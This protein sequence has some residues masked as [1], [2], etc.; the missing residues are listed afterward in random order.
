[1]IGG[2][3]V[4]SEN[5]ITYWDES[6]EPVRTAF[7]RRMGILDERG[8]LIVS[9]A[10]HVQKNLFFFLVQSE[11]GDIYKV[12]LQYDLEAGEVQE[13][14]VKYFDTIP[15]SVSICVLKTGFLFSASECGNHY[16]F[17]FR[18]IGDD[19]DETASTNSK[20]VDLVHFLPRA[21][22]NL[23]LID[24]MESLA[25]IQDL[26]VVNLVPNEDTPQIYTL[27]GRG[28]RASLRVLRHG[29]AVS[30]IAVSELPG[31][32]T[33]VWAVKTRSADENHKYIVVS[34]I[35]ATIVLQVGETVTEVQDSGIIYDTETL[36]MGTLFDNSIVQIHPQG[37]RQIY[38]DK[39]QA[40]WKLGKAGTKTV[41]ACAMNSRQI[42]IAVAGGQLIYFTFGGVG[43]Q[44]LSESMRKDMNNEICSLA[45]AP[46][47]EGRNHS[48]FL[49]VGLANNQ[50]KVISLDFKDSM[51]QLTLHAMPNRPHSLALV[52]LP[53]S[54]EAQGS[55]A[56][57]L[58]VGLDSGVLIRSRLDDSDGN[59]T[60]TRRRFIGSMPVKLRVTQVQGQQA[61]MAMSSR[62]W[63][64]Y[65]HQARFH[66]TPLSYELLEDAS[67]FSSP[68][69]SEGMVCVAGNTLRILMNE[70]LGEMF[71]QTVVPLRY[72]P[73]K[74]LVYPGTNE[75]IVIETDHNAFS[76][77]KKKALFEGLMETDAEGEKK[78]DEA[79]DE[80]A[81]DAFVGAPQAG[82]G[83]WGSCIRVI[84]PRED[85]TSFLLELQDNEA[86]FSM[87]ICEFKK[88]DGSTEQY[89]AVGTVKDMQITPARSHNGG[90]IH[91]YQ[92]VTVGGEDDKTVQLKLYHSTPVA[93]VPLALAPFKNRL[94]AGVGNVLR[95]YDLGKQKL[96]RKC[97]NKSFP[98]TISSLSSQGDRIYCGDLCES[99]C[100][101]QYREE[102]GT[103]SIFADSTSPRFVTAVCYIDYD[104]V[105]VADKFGNIVVHRLPDET[106]KKSRKDPT[107]LL[108]DEY[109]ENMG[110][111]AHKFD[112]LIQ[113]HVGDT[114]TS[115][116]KTVLR[117]G[118]DEVLIYSTLLGAIGIFKPIKAKEDVSFFQH[119][120]MH[121]RQETSALC[122]RDHM[123]FRSYYFPVK[124]TCDGD[125]CET[126]TLLPHERQS[127][128]AAEL[129]SSP[130]DV[131]KKLE[132]TRNFIL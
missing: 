52:T 114:V 60:D 128:I 67:P 126:F 121:L 49:V 63:L 132:E 82:D 16:L 62:S 110:G 115:I 105:C 120:E 98:A 94:L 38:P 55:Q 71:N 119:L 1:M 68:Q 129:L 93:D 76:E 73:R 86:A 10:T 6:H 53:D 106:S 21:P 66:M 15:T 102:L 33:G 88:K 122:G 35:N 31:H 26:K 3:L 101:V 40:E 7:P 81:Q 29:L 103:F 97:E 80:K 24:E 58:Y 77:E 118:G 79:D 22:H 12:T 131:H 25:T 32:P 108:V 124:E 84:N 2:V 59:I 116:Q 113:Y 54:S 123:S 57:F 43:G 36:M 125:L 8:I 14:Q 70:R 69:C 41:K 20:S 46:V 96:L 51:R 99:V 47:P 13:V 18:G 78:E 112:D 5:Y 44:Q 72:T 85:K 130:P 4:C 50:V 127:A 45:I 39:R 109:G 27:C 65:S 37:F 100:M 111:A 91:I 89:L 92:F 87:C 95:L 28:A 107:L 64:S 23:L 104:T 90:F 83:Q 30:E 75:L 11:F 56:L 17:Q 74:M 42:V 34:F 61:V 117:P 19:S 48:Q 9:H